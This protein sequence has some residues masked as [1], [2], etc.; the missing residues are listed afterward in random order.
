MLQYSGVSTYSHSSNFGTVMLLCP[1]EVVNEGY[2][3]KP[4]FSSWARKNAKALMKDCSDVKEHG[5][6]I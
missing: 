6:F 1:A 4:T 2:Q 5:F 3:R